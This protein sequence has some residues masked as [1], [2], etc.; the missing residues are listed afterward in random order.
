MEIIAEGKHPFLEKGSRVDFFAYSIGAFLSQILFIANPK[1]MLSNSKLFLFCGGARFSEMFGTSRLIMDS[2]AFISLRRYY[3]G[4]FLRELK[5]NSPFSNYIR[6]SAL[7]NAFRAMLAP[8]S[9]KSFREGIFQKLSDQVKIVALTKDQVIPA[10][11]IQSTFSCIKHRVKNMVEVLDFP[12][13][14][15]HEV[16]FPVYNNPN[17]LMVDQCFERVFKPAIEFFK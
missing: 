9:L 13:E 6:N 3:L 14:Y 15:S 11:Y 2:Q 16:P 1:D 5:T 17:Y 10:K 12:Y 7:G 8:E 4:E